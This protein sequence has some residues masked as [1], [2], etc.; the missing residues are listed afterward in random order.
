M[1]CERKGCGHP[2]ALHNPCS[3]CACRAFEP[4]DRKEWV[5]TLT[6]NRIRPPTVTGARRQ[7]ALNLARAEAEE[8][9][10]G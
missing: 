8:D 1:D 10:R 7:D 3:R 9:V 5:A 2:L 6:D 4:A